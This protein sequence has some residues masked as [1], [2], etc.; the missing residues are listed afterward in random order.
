MTK[1]VRVEAVG[2]KNIKTGSDPGGDLEIYG[3]LAAWAI[4]TNSSGQPQHRVEHFF[5]RKMNPSQR[6]SITQGATLHIGDTTEITIRNDEELWVG[7]HLKEQDDTSAN[8]S[9]G[10]R[11]H[12]IPH[13]VIQSGTQKVRFHESDQHVDAIF[14]ITVL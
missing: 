9:M 8:D 13:N 7:G 10:D 3:H 4:F 12:K 1:R 5:Y 11:H 2:I 14:E 6:V